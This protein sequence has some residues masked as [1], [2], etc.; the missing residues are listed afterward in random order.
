MPPLPSR[1]SFCLGAGLFCLTCAIRCNFLPAAP[2]RQGNAEWPA[3]AC[4]PLCSTLRCSPFA[5]IVRRKSSQRLG[6]MAK[7][8]PF[9]SQSIALG[10]RPTRIRLAIVP[11]N[12]T[13]RV[14]RVS[15]SILGRLALAFCCYFSLCNTASSDCLHLHPNCGE[16]NLGIVKWVPLG[17]W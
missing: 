16:A 2:R 6:H 8:P 1:P 13:L 11:R 12:H 3:Y 5:T 17:V 7:T 4:F 10:F 15:L 9:A 14:L